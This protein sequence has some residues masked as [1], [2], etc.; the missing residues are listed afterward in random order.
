MKR[1]ADRA[2]FF[3][4]I[5][6]TLPAAPGTA[7]FAMICGAAMVGAG[8]PPLAAIAAGA[9]V[10]GGTI[11]LAS[12]Q[13]LS[14]GAPFL[15]I[16]GACL[17]INLRFVMFSASIAPYLRRSPLLRRVLMSYAMSDN[18]Y[19]AAITRFTR[20]EHEKAPQSEREAF[21]LGAAL[22]IWIAWQTATVAGVMLGAAIPPGWHLEFTV[23]LTFLALGLANIHDKATLAAA[24]VAGVTAVAAADMPFRMGL[25]LAA[26]AGVAAGMATERL[27]R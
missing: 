12:V 15:V 25:I 14:T 20:P 19:A 17:V 3:A 11:Q 1:A 24:V 4:G 16:L 27:R 5:R 26:A 18:G 23:A 8:M 2:A 22:S 10:Y 9:L 13:L 21:F 6:S 7:T